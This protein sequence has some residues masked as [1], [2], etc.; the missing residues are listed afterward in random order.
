MMMQTL[1]RLPFRHH[2]GRRFV[3][4]LVALLGLFHA[5]AVAAPPTVRWVDWQQQN[6]FAVEGDDYALHVDTGPAKLASL[7]IGDVDLLGPAGVTL[8][9]VGDAGRLSVPPVEFVPEWETWKGQKYLPATSSRARMNVW[10]AGPYYWDAHLLDVPL[11]RDTDLAALRDAPAVPPVAV[12][13]FIRGPN[14]FTPLNG[15]TLTAVA[16]QGTDVRID[17]SDPQVQSPALKVSGPSYLRVTLDSPTDGEME[18]FWQ[19]GDD[20][21]YAGARR[22][23]TRVTAGKDQRVAVR[24]PDARGLTRLRIDPP[25]NVRLKRL[26]IEPSPPSTAAPPLRGEF[27]FH[28][29]RDAL[30]ITSKVDQAVRQI[31]WAMPGFNAR[32]QT[33]AGRTF[34]IRDGQGGRAAVLLPADSRFDAKNGLLTMPSTK[35]TPPTVVVRWVRDGRSLEQAFVNDLT[36]LPPQSF[37]VSGG[38]SV[39]FDPAA[40]VYVLRTDGRRDAFS[41]EESYRNP[42]R[43]METNLTLPTDANGREVL[44]K[45]ETG[46]G[47][48]EAAVVA[49]ARGF[50]LPLPA[51]VSKN[52]AGEKEEP[53][54]TAFGDSYVPFALPADASRT[55]KL[56]HLTHGWGQSPLKQVSSVR[57]FHVYWHLSTGAS[58]STCYTLNWMDAAFRGAREPTSFLIPDF[59]PMS[60]PMWRD[61]PQHGS[62]QFPG[63]LQYNSTA[64]LI[65]ERTDFD[66]IAPLLARF[67]MRYRTSDDAATA[68]VTVLEVP[69]TDE[70]RSFVRVRY[71]WKKPV[72]IDGDARLNFRLATM[73]EH[74]TPAEI[75][76][77]DA[78]GNT[79]TRTAKADNR[80]VLL[81]EP[82]AADGPFVAGQ[83]DWRAKP[84]VNSSLLLVRSV[85]GRVGGQ[86]VD[87]LAASARFAGKSGSYWVTLPREAV[88][89][90]AGDWIEMDVQFMPAGEPAPA[91][92][93]P[94]RERA[95]FATTGRPK[96]TSVTVG[97]HVDDFPATLRSDRGAASFVLS[98]GNKVMPIVI[99]DWPADAV[100]I[101]W[102]KGV[103]LDRQLHGGDDYQI[104]PT[105]NGTTRAVLAVPI[106]AGQS[107][108]LTVT[109]VRGDRGIES[110]RGENGR[111][112]VTTPADSKVR[113][114]APRPFTPGTN[115]FDPKRH[116]FAFE[117]T[118]T[119]STELPIRV[120]AKT[121]VR[122]RSRMNSD[123]I[124]V[125]TDGPATIEL[126]AD[127]VAAGWHME[128]ATENPEAVHP[129]AGAKVE[130]NG[131]GTVR[132]VAPKGVSE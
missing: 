9:A 8:H 91:W 56:L 19:A 99:E 20:A 18:I 113:L 76:W 88:S 37:G 59:R 104:E 87:R 39:G 122:I 82:L 101:T 124:T 90:D 46:V 16:G 102:V 71:D 69:Q 58:E 94:E 1:P 42:G 96:A 24:I 106:R 53:D 34:L 35:A 55:V 112:V 30:R 115:R 123:T 47:N 86:A 33:T 23:V 89:I 126:D 3:F 109:G 17:G 121:A 77:S 129:V 67:T 74:H 62:D 63:L 119:R 51:Q 41:F 75:V 40:G 10:S 7:R 65:Y 13:D 22:T 85:R 78:D 57:F 2:S 130:L 72:K 131:P 116:L 43:R 25:G 110:V 52:F 50:P 31:E 12:F 6:R 108:P 105:G 73:F 79:Q 97:T 27:V 4:P 15:V 32:P 103:Y 11:M 84:A 118:A 127:R 81:G 98:G 132:L 28:A 66:S 48:L 111:L 70:M 92:L 117:G 49:D 45:T 120:T 60:G 107:L 64:R 38:T 54:D 68:N 100:P 128:M 36:P 61:Q 83:P 44:V 21:G 114:E 93:K 14:G 29:H 95:A 5:V 26:T 125:D 80:P